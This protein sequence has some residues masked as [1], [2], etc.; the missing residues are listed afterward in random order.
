VPEVA[1]HGVDPSAVGGVPVQ[2]A[3]AKGIHF[4][5]TAS[6]RNKAYLKNWASDEAI[7]Y[8]RSFRDVVRDVMAVFDTQCGDRKRARGRS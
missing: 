5:G 4:I 2:L 1:I 3:H 7:D 8:A 6:Q